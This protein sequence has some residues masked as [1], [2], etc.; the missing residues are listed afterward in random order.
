M[1][2]ACSPVQQVDVVCPE[3]PQAFLYG[4]PDVF[5]V[6]SDLAAA[7]GIHMGAKL[8]GQEDLQSVSPVAAE[9]LGAG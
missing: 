2:P 3:T 7:G 5:C 1:T 9:M 4:N 8:C 6:V